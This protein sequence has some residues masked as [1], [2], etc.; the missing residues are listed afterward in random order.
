MISLYIAGTED[1]VRCFFCGG[2]LSNW[3]S[4][5]D[6]WV[7]HAHWFPEC[8][9]LSQ[10]KGQ[11]FIDWVKEMVRLQE[12]DDY[13]ICEQQYSPPVQEKEIIL[14]S[15]AACSLYEMGYS[16]TIVQK[17]ATS[18]YAHHQSTPMAGNLMTEIFNI[19]DAMSREET[20]TDPISECEKETL[21]HSIKTTST[22][23]ENDNSCAAN[24]AC[25]SDECIETELES[26]KK[27]N[28]KLKDMTMCKIC[29]DNEINIVFLPC[30]HMTACGECAPAMRLCP[31]CRTKVKGTV[32]AYF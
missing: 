27:E 28:R 17:A 25:A 32:R 3:E 24:E 21:E 26:L 10:C 14:E 8:Q 30:G 15:A 7:E 2:G 1:L 23:A 18:W 13:N 19:E 12:C 4:E 11:E 22:Q 16:K 29:M 31:L 6:P 20:Y 9:F 5:D